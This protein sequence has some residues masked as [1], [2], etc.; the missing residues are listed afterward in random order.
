MNKLDTIFIY[1]K[2]MKWVGENLEKVESNKKY[3]WVKLK[4][5]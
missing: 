4:T 1:N 2:S 5:F 3:Q